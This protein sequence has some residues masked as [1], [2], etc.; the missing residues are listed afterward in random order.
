MKR[1]FFAVPISDE[2]QKLLR[3]IQSN[4]RDLPG[5][6]R[7][8]PPENVH[9]TIKFIGE[10]E[11]VVATNL[12]SQVDNLPLPERFSITVN[13]TGVFPHPR[14]PRVLWVGTEDSTS[15]EKIAGQ[16]DDA[17]EEDGIEP[18]TRE[19]H[20][21]LTL[22]R[23]KGHGLPGETLNQFLNYEVPKISMPVESVVCYE[24]ILK[25]AGAEYTALHTTNLL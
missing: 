9:L 22:G 10:V 5:K 15:L 14:R 19:F 8:V 2:V 24:S 11:E 12:H 21:H 6:I 25:P 13:R 18:E 3:E 7:W 23:V 4:L 1:I 20:P 17:F 16:L